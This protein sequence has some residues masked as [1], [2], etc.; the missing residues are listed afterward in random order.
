M[1]TPS[2]YKMAFSAITGLSP[3]NARTILDLTGG[4]QEFFELP[5]RDL[6]AL[7]RCDNRIFSREYRDKLLEAARNEIDMLENRRIKFIYFNDE[8]YPQ[9]LLDTE[10]APLRLFVAGN[11]NLNAKRITAV[12]GTRHSTPYGLAFV[13]RLTADLATIHP[14]MLIVSGLAYGTDISAHRAALKNGMPTVGVLAHGLSTIYPPSHRDDV[15]D[16]VASDGGVI[17]EYGFNA[18]IHRGNFLARNRIVAGL[19]DCLILVESAQKGGAMITSELASNYGR[20]LMALPGRTTDHYSEGCNHLIKLGMAQLINS[21]DDIL[22]AMNWNVPVEGRQKEMFV[23]FTPE[24]Q[25]I[26]DLLRT[27]GVMTTSAVASALS[28]S[29]GKLTSLIMTLEFK[30]VVANLPGAKVMLIQ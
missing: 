10:D 5:Q 9:R 30:G 25:P 12:V 2:L 7:A 18:P 1:G 21:T 11:P 20:R 15:A 6:I 19:C 17:T 23:T 29:P 14:D 26:V 8:E 22:D 4:E 27:N 16:M 13:N 3:D 24:E 28:L